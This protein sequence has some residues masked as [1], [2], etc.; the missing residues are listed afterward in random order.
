MDELVDHGEFIG[1]GIAQNSENDTSAGQLVPHGAIPSDKF[2]SKASCEDI[3]TANNTDNVL[4]RVFNTG[5]IN[6]NKTM[7]LVIF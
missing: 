7:K 1:R 6:M 3:S 5:C 2:I 4:I